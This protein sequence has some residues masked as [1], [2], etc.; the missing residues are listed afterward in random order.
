MSTVTVERYGLFPELPVEGEWTV[1]HLERLPDDGRRYE[2]FDGVLVVSPA[3]ILDHQRVSRAIFHLL[4]TACPPDF[5]V[6]Y[7]P[8]DFQ[9]TKERSFQP[10]VLV[11]RKR[12]TEGETHRL[13]KPPVLAVEVLSPSTMSLDRIFKREMYALS[14]VDLFW[15]FDPTAVKFVAYQRDGRSYV[16]TARAKGDKRLTL[17][18]PYPVEIC[19]AEIVKGTGGADP[20]PGS[21]RLIHRFE[22]A[23]VWVN[24]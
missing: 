21:Q 19:P 14:G 23:L 22:V 15:I 24:S 16:E 13:T 6:F 5:E 9:P 20:R 7:A 11:A 10:D 8:V 1:D 2:L 3:P 18:R 4:Y 17:E 12:D